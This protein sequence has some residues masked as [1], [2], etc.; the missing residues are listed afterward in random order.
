MAD[1]QFH[2]KL[3]SKKI[4]EHGDI[5]DTFSQRGNYDGNYIQPVK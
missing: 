1:A 2:T 3:I 4:G 5:A